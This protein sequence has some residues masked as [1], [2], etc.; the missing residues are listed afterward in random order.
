MSLSA[1]LRMRLTLS[2]IRVLIAALI[3]VFTAAVAFVV[4]MPVST[5]GAS[6]NGDHISV[7]AYDASH[8]ATTPPANF[9]AG[10]AAASQQASGVAGSSARGFVTV[11]AAEDGLTWAEQSGIR[12]DAAA[13]TGNFGLG[14]AT[15]SEADVLGQAWVGEGSTVASDGKTLLSEDGMRQYRPPSYKPNL[16]IQQANFE[17]RLPG[18]LSRG[19]QGNGHL[20][21]TGP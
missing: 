16:G 21:I 6:F 3:V 17:S 5:L 11:V 19:W 14:S 20:D 1:R 4:A 18:Q 2:H 7:Y 8:T 13:G 9:A 12:R 10:E 15:A